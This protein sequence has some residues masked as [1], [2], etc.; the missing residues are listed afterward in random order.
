MQ[1]TDIIK[2]CNG[3]SACLVACKLAALKMEGTEEGRIKKRPVKNEGR[4]NKCNACVLYCPLYNPVTMPDFEDYY[5]FTEEYEGRNL[6]EIYRHT[7]RSVKAGDF[8]EFVGTLC[9]IAGLKS[10]MGDKFRSN[11]RVYPLYCEEEKRAKDPACQCCVFYE[12]VKDI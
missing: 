7:M 12:E 3:C 8:T 6:P 5:R 10:L 11:L 1:L 9:E 4:C 2:N